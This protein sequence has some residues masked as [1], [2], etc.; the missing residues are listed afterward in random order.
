MDELQSVLDELSSLDDGPQY[1]HSWERAP[2]HNSHVA[3]QEAA[4]WATLEAE[5]AELDSLSARLP[6]SDFVADNDCDGTDEPVVRQRLVVVDG[7]I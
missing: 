3:A 4:V 6:K 7:L 2:Q 5:L 1:E